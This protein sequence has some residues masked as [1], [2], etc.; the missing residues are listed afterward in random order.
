MEE[1]KN[2]LGNLRYSSL[3]R[4]DIFRK[5]PNFKDFPFA[6]IHIMT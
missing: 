4:I 6:G 5:A 1:I 3:E 2:K